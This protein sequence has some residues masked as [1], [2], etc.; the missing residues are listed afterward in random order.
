M[1]GGITPNGSVRW[2]IEADKHENESD[3]GNS[4]FLL[5]GSDRTQRDQFIG[6]TVQLPSLAA[7]R[8]A[9]LSQLQEQLSK[10]TADNRIASVTVYL[11][12]ED[13]SSEYSVPS[14]SDSNNYDPDDASHWQIYFDWSLKVSDL[15]ANVRQGWR[16]SK[17]SPLT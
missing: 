9:L 7:N 1:P 15:P 10:A 17:G 11:P 14:P 16:S 2:F 6:L 13:A 5:E 12:L 8:A 4:K 3:R